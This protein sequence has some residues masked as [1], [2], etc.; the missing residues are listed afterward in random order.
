ML[1]KNAPYV[2]VYVYVCM[3]VCVYVCVYVCMCVC[4][5]VLCVRG[6]MCYVCMCVYVLSV[7][8]WGKR[9]CSQIR[10]QKQH[11]HTH[12]HTHTYIYTYTHT[13]THTHIYTYTQFVQKQIH[14]SSVRLST[15]V[16]IGC[17]VF[18]HR[19]YRSQSMSSFLNCNQA[20]RLNL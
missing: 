6:C 10:T 14:V 8:R 20:R 5:Y 2:C 9:Y 18:E 1:Q 19:C 4:V 12:T 7:R 13:H 16:C 3:C 17:N 11:T 15:D